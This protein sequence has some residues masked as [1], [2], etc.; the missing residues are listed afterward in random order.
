M[1]TEAE[2]FTVLLRDRLRARGTGQPGRRLAAAVRDLAEAGALPPGARLPSERE[3]AP[4][5][6][7]SRGTV[8]AA[9]RSLVL[10]GLCERRTGSGT[11]VV[12]HR[13]QEGGWG[14]GHLM[15]ADPLVIDLSKSVVADPS[16][17]RLPAFDPA[18][19]LHAPHQHGYDAMGDPRLRAGLRE[20][21]GDNFMITSGA[22]HGIDL[23]LRCA[24]RQGDVVLVE[25]TTYPGALAVVRRCG[26]Q[27]VPVPCDEDGP[28]PGAFRDAVDRHRPA[29]AFLMGVHSPTG[30]VTPAQRVAELAGIA[31][32][33]DVLLVEDRALAEVVHTGDA[34]LPYATGHPDGT[35]T[36]G[37]LSK[38]LWGGLRIGWVSA[39]APL[40]SRLAEL[41]V[42]NDLA[43]S[44]VGQR[45]AAVLLEQAAGDQWRQELRRRRDHL[46]RA[47]RR[48]LP[49]WR[50]RTPDGGLSLW[51]R[52]PGADAERFAHLAQAYGVAVA[53]GT[54]FSPDGRHRE[55]LRLSFALAPELLDQ[56]VT[57]LAAAWQARH[58]ASGEGDDRIGVTV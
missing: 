18:E 42:E 29:C 55:H 17:L 49:S 25:E 41:K 47:L 11:Y 3:L 46:S 15:R 8:A 13:P 30:R 53:P 32:A 50:W 22:Q 28:S 40:L 10:A 37:S 58:S 4:A 26:A 52:V 21:A 36:V 12:D 20:R 38:T 51:V 44:V 6:G 23:A 9:Y 34:P 33:A 14:F 48:D 31:R 1:R 7:M 24:V 16:F 45:M 27:P 5:V 56:A 54:L 39:P 35:I 2:R 19:L 57:A 43:T